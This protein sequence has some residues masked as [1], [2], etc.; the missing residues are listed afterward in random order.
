MYVLRFPSWLA[1]T[2]CHVAP[3]SREKKISTNRN[4]PRTRFRQATLSRFPTRAFVRWR[5]A[6]STTFGATAHGHGLFPLT[7]VAV[8]RLGEQADPRLR[9]R[10]VLSEVVAPAL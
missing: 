6:R 9:P 4:S 10:L 3:P 7:E 2:N 1:P 8:R 5:G